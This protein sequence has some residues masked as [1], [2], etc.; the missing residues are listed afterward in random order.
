MSLWT[1]LTTIVFMTAIAFA[2]TTFA[3]PIGPPA[4]RPAAAGLSFTDLDLGSETGA[5][6]ALARVER[7]VLE[8]CGKASADAS[9]TYRRCADA[10]IEPAV[11]A[12]GGPIGS[13][14]DT[15][16]RDLLMFV[17]SR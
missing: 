14:V 16:N 1:I 7:A 12:L 8:R 6:A 3:A 13:A 10:V 15:G 17:A 9:A 4:P 11:S 2:A 5:T